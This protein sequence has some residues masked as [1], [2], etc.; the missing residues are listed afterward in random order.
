[1]CPF[2]KGAPRQV[3]VGIFKCM[4]YKNPPALRATSFQKGGQKYLQ[5]IFIMHF[6]YNPKNKQFWKVMRNQ[7]TM[8]KAEW[9]LRNLVLKWNQT[10]YRFLRQKPIWNY[11]L[12][13]YC[14]KLKLCIE[15]DDQSHDRKWEEDEIRTKYLNSLWIQVIRYTNNQIYYQLDWVILDLQEQLK[16]RES[17]II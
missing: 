6:L 1:M 13:F 15:V 17:E 3:G 5:S 9:I 2:T 8:T 16:E 10:W 4:M 7:E 11:I 12:D 14:A